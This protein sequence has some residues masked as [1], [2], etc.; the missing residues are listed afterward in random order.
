[1]GFVRD[2]ESHLL[3]SAVRIAVGLA[4]TAS[5]IFERYRED[6]ENGV[7][8]PFAIG[9]RNDA[10][11]FW[12]IRGLYHLADDDVDYL[13]LEA[14]ADLPASGQIHVFSVTTRC[15]SPGEIVT[16]IG[17]RFPKGAKSVEVVDDD[18]AF[19][20]VVFKGEQIISKGAVGQVYPARRDLSMV[21]FPAFEVL[22][23]AIGGMS[24]GAV[25]DAAGDLIGVISTSWETIDLR[26]PTTAAWIGPTMGRAVECPWPPGVVMKS[27]PVIDIAHFVEGREYLTVKEDGSAQLKIWPEDDSRGF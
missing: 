27:S 25:L 11:E 18:L 4:A 19:S 23:G 20:R 21:R 12:K 16:M 24:G 17:F 3:G 2:G 22:A 6:I 9:L 1:M 5:H 8:V 10:L 13:A 7:V 14:G 15:P 26:G